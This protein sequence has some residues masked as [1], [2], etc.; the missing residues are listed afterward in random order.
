MRSIAIEM[1]PAARSS[2]KGADEQEYE[3]WI[4]AFGLIQPTNLPVHASAEALRAGITMHDR[5]KTALGSHRKWPL[6]LRSGGRLE[7]PL[8][9]L[10]G[11]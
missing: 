9:D 10:C 1:K 2:K 5:I 3:Y 4:A 7:P 11:A 8:Q 6:D